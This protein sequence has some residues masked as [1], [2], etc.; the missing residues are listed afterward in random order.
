MVLFI[1]FFPRYPVAAFWI[2]IFPA[3]CSQTPS[4]FVDGGLLGCI[5]LWTCREI[6]RFGGTCCPEDRCSMFLR[7]VGIHLHVHTASQPTKTTIDIFTAAITSNLTFNLCCSFLIVKTNQPSNLTSDVSV[8]IYTCSAYQ[9][10]PCFIDS[11]ISSP[12]TQ[13]FDIA[14][15]SHSG[16]SW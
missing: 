7:N 13:K 15:C 8:S 5:A 1:T 9:E 12:A 11:N 6:Q 16:E 2:E 4:V 3:P 10:M 14:L